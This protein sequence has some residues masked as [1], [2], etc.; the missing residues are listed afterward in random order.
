MPTGYTAAVADGEI[1]TLR[2]FALRC[3]R[4]V[5]YE[6]MIAQVEAWATKAEG[7]RDFML[8][9]LRESIEW[10]CSDRHER[11]APE[12]LTGEVWRAAKLKR[13]SR[14]LGY[15]ENERAKEI[16]RTNERNRWLADLRA[17]LPESVPV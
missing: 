4:K 8:Q 2:D 1:T 15:H 3:A 7:I 5:R 16:E 14:D 9:Q 12:R 13:A 17:S 10:D 11:E 6:A